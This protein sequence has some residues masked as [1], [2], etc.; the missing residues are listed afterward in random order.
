MPLAAP[1]ATST[2][3]MARAPMSHRD[4]LRMKSSFRSVTRRA[5][6][7]G[8]AGGSRAARRGLQAA[9]NRLEG[10]FIAGAKV[11]CYDHGKRRH[12]VP[13]PRAARGCDRW[14][15]A[16]TRRGQAA[17]GAGRPPASG[18]RG[19]AARTADRRGLGYGS[20]SVCRSY[21]RVVRVEAA[22]A[23]ERARADRLSRRG[24]GY[25]IDLHGARLDALAFVELHESAALA[26]ALEEHANVL[27]LA[28][29]ALALWRGPALADVAL[30]SAGRAEAE[31]FE[32]LRLR[33]Y[34]MRFDAE[35]ALGHQRA[36]HRGTAGVRRAESVSRAIRRAVHARA[37]RGGAARGGAR[38][39]YEQTRRRL[40]TISA[41]S[42][43]LT[44][45]SSPARS[46]GRIRPLRRPTPPSPRPLHKC[47][48]GQGTQDTAS[49]GRPR[50]QPEW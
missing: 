19:R 47:V 9:C 6:V 31:R 30:A 21:A 42:R 32:E 17:G 20:T 33:T 12:R 1:T 40:T 11:L 16:R 35:L 44:C 45:S 10:A 48:S 24:P 3:V 26:S 37:V 49:P 14:R 28:L 22:A 39:A 5:S 25:A 18:R 50:R 4:K 8:L 43:A 23:S 15:A 27:E 7:V 2:A 38:G 29:S 34:E 36:G 46:S 41:S 13:C